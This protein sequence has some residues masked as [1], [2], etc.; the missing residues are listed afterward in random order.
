MALKITNNLKDFIQK[1]L[2]GIQTLGIIR[3]GTVVMQK[4]SPGLQF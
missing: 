1:R 3:L 2:T 4:L